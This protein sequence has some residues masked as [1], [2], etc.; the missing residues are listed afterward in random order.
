MNVTI[1]YHLVRYE[2]QVSSTSHYHD[3]LGVQ[4]SPDVEV[5]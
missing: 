3:F 5:A 2:P 1:G 4:Q